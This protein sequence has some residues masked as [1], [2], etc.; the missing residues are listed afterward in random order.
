MRS[1]PLEKALVVVSI[2]VHALLKLLTAL[3]SVT[4]MLCS[5]EPLM[6]RCLSTGGAVL[7]FK[8]LPLEVAEAS[9]KAIIEGLGLADKSSEERIKALL[10][11]PQDDLWQKVPQ[12]A[13]LL[14]V[15]DNYTV[16]GVPDFTIVSS[17]KDNPSFL[18]PGRKWCSG[19]MI[20]ESKLDANIL[21]YLGLDARNPGIAK[22][23]IDSA[24]ATLSS[25]PEVASQLFS[26]YNITADIP[27]NDAM[28]S[29]LRFASEMCFYAPAR[30][31]AQGWPSS[32]KFFLYHFNE[33]I[34]WE[35]RFQG[36][37]GHILDVSYLF[38]NYNQ[39]LDEKQKKVARAYAEDFIK[40][41][42]GEDPWPPV[43][44]GKLG[45]RVYGPS[46]E[47]IT[48]KYVEDGKPSEVGRGERVSELGELAGFDCFVEVFQNFLQGR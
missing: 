43:Q 25:R 28:L 1:L 38:Q 24:K 27:D 19:L 13:P 7:L 10:S 32:S 5:K 39:H 22:K 4:M 6:K 15:M 29:I 14:P 40:F 31:F 37:A 36:E 9:Y 2:S 8:P 20:G 47:G 33:G 26:A 12:S 35:G 16:P 46:S 3:V 44:G 11:I 34:P 21:A 18:M 17:Q 23:F 42:N 48:T 30:A 41:V 45:G